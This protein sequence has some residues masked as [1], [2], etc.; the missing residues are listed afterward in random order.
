MNTFVHK[1][2]SVLGI[3]SLGIEL[4]SGIIELNGINILKMLTIIYI[5]QIT[6][7]IYAVYT[8]TAMDELSLYHTVANFDYGH[9]SMSFKI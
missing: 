3:I 7:Q 9:L 4:I 1:A 6:F 2:S 5:H 8:A